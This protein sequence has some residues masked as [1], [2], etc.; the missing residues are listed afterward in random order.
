MDPLTTS[1]E[2]SHIAVPEVSPQDLAF[3]RLMAEILHMP[4]ETLLKEL[5]QRRESGLVTSRAVTV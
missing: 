3:V 5:V 4:E 1:I 2:E